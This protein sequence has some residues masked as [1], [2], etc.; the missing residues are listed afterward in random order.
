LK[1]AWSL[2]VVLDPGEVERLLALGRQVLEK[3]RVINLTG[4]R[5]LP[6]L[7]TEH[8]LD[9]LT[10]IPFIRE[11]GKTESG[12]HPLLVDVGSGG[13]FPALPLAIVRADLTVLCIESVSK[14]A[15]ALE[16]LAAALDLKG[17]TVANDRAERMAHNSAWR[18]KADW[19]TARGVGALATVCELALPFL[20][21]GGK[22]LAQKGPDVVNEIEDVCSTVGQLGG[23][24]RQVL[25]VGPDRP[26]GKHTVV[27]VEKV[28]STPSEFPRRPGLPAKR[29]LRDP[30]P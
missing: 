10:L 26:G 18:E 5:D 11:R 27:I 3:N 21:L 13:G 9:S 19:A 17:V 15:R 6:T 29:P 16:Q 25:T 28:E 20:C 8:I 24:A 12:D 14:K 23:V 1:G 22:L 2:G 7:V 4:G 30:R